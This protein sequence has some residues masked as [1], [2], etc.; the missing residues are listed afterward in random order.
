MTGTEK[1]RRDLLVIYRAA[2]ER[3]DGHACV[4]CHLEAHPPGGAVA[5]VAVGKAACAMTLGA[6]EILGAGVA[7]ALVITA[8]DTLEQGFGGFRRLSPSVLPQVAFL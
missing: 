4:R 6:L 7:D 1:L 8:R 3:V 5:L 2:L